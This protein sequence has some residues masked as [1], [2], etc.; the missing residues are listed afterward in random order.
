MRES[1]NLR[2]RP[3]ALL[4]IMREDVSTQ[5]A[6]MSRRCC[7]LH[8]STFLVVALLTCAIALAAVPGQVV[9][10]TRS[11]CGACH[12]YAH[13]WPWLYFENYVQYGMGD[14]HYRIDEELPPWWYRLCW[15]FGRDATMRSRF[16]PAILALDALCCMLVVCGVGLAAEW[17]R[18]RRLRFWQFSLADLLAAVLL[19]AAVLGWWRY[20]HDRH[21]KLNSLAKELEK[22]GVWL[23]FGYCGPTWLARLIGTGPLEVFCEPVSARLIGNPARSIGELS[24]H[25][26]ELTHLRNIDLDPSVR[27]GD[28]FP[29]EIEKQLIQK[30]TQLKSVKRLSISGSRLDDHALE[31]IAEMPRLS[32]LSLMMCDGMTDADIAR[33]HN[34]RRLEQVWLMLAPLPAEP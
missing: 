2:R 18:R 28:T 4:V 26:Q 22:S 1:E 15:S 6:A 10:C 33:L 9:D 25:R 34:N 21:D 29:A 12:T 20:Q 5:Q 27:N 30:L 11:W 14:D 23:Q 16:R 24:T 8:A 3:K 19:F 7:H 32:E 13:G 17:W 31:R